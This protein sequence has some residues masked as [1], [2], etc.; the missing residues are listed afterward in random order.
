MPIEL[1]NYIMSRS[2]YDEES[3]RLIRSGFEAEQAEEILKI[4]YPKSP[5]NAERELVHRGLIT[6]VTDYSEYR[7]KYVESKTIDFGYELE[8]L[9][10]HNDQAG[11]TAEDIDNMADRLAH[12]GY[13]NGTAHYAKEKEI[14]YLEQDQFFRDSHAE[15]V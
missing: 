10:D 6:R 4:Q 15:V 7:G 12:R 14:S 9:P 5:F 13:L 8:L 1:P 2:E 11:F 3:E